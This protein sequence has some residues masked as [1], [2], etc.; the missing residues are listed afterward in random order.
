MDFANAIRLGAALGAD[1]MEA[2]S[3]WGYWDEAEE[4]GLKRAAEMH[5]R[6][7]EVAEEN[8]VTIV[9]ETLRP[10]ESRIG[11]SLQQMKQL[12]DLVDHPRFKVMIDLTAM[13]VSGETIQQWFDVLE[14]KTLYM[15]IF[16]IVIPMGITSG[17]KG[18]ET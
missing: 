14:R 11:Y 13:S 9:A 5:Q 4:D 8:G 15:H 18:R 17:V 16:R 12:F 10:Q 3:G 6:L 2:N 7:C 1:K